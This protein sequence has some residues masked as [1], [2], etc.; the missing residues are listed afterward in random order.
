MLISSQI[1]RF[2]CFSDDQ[3]FS[4]DIEQGLPYGYQ[5]QIKNGADHAFIS[6]LITEMFFVQGKESLLKKTAEYWARK[7][8][9][10]DSV[11]LGYGAFP[12]GGENG[13]KMQ[14][15]YQTLFLQR[16]LPMKMKYLMILKFIER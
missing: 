2:K 15:G 5:I 11:S 9:W 8:L 3:G 6:F 4:I 7:R 16:A 1:D 12:M 10:N 13:L 14:N